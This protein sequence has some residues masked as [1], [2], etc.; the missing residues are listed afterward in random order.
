LRREQVVGL[1]TGDKI[2][3]QTQIYFDFCK[4]AGIKPEIGRTYLTFKI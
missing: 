3:Q 4:T 2:S 1:Q